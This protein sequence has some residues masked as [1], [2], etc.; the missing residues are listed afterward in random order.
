MTPIQPTHVRYIKLGPAGRWARECIGA[1]TLPLGHHSADHALCEAGSWDEVTALRRAA[2]RSPGK[3]TDLTREVRDF[4]ELGSDCLWITFSDRCLWW[5]FADPQVTW[6]G[7]D[8]T[9]N[10]SRFRRM[11]D[12]WRNTDL[13]GRPLRME[14]LSTWL[15]QV[16]NYR[17]TICTVKAADYLIR[18]LNGERDPIVVEADA[19]RSRLTRSAGQLIAQL[20][21]A[22]FELMVDLIFARGGWQRVSE[23]GGTMADVDLVLEQPTL[24]ERA[25]VQVKSTASQ[26]ILDDHLAFFAGSG[27]D[28]TFF[29]CHSPQ[30]P[31]SAGETDAAHVWTG[32]VLAKQAVQAGLF[33][34]LVAK[35]G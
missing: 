32:N 5:G 24:G 16:G 22:D 35:V 4:Y 17:Q 19:A 29:V 13:A 15:T 30:G 28:R 6:L 23:V 9:E 10:P 3:A 18:R 33:D 11:N 27:H 26:A 25:L 20:H 2:G 12:G 7:A 1:G 31:L 21:W 34:W 14:E 8:E